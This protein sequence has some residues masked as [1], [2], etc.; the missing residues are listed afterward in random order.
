MF[1]NIPYGTE[2]LCLNYINLSSYPIFLLG[3]NY[4]DS[5]TSRYLIVIFKTLAFKHYLNNNELGRNVKH[6]KCL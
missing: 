4:D 6:E 3:F 5:E 1:N 2:V